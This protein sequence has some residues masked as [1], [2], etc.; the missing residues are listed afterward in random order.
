MASMRAGMPSVNPSGY[1]VFFS[2]AA[3]PLM[4]KWI[5][6]SRDSCPSPEHC[7]G[8]DPVP[9]E[10]FGTRMH[11]IIQGDFPCLFRHIPVFMAIYEDN[12]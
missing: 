10:P 12:Y 7:S 8:R 4:L 3:M 6:C 2:P 1:T 11:S 9:L 5:A